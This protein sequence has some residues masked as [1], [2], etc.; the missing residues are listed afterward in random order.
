M[1]YTKRGHF[2]FVRTAAIDA[3]GR[4][5]DFFENRRQEIREFLVPLLRDPDMHVRNATCAA[6]AT[7]GDPAA[8]GELQ[9][10]QQTDI[11][12]MTQ[13][14]ARRAIRRIRDRQADAGK[15]HE[16]AADVDKLKDEN[17]KLQQRVSKLESQVQAFSKKRK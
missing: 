10:V 9:K 8:V 6:L 11:M 14:A 1:S 5:G 3:L 12:G 16:F 7:N 17:L 4:F 13:R 15:K 2:V